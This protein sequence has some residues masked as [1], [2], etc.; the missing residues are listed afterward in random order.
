MSETQPNILLIVVDQWRSDTLGCA[1]HPCVRTPHLDRL[2]AD[3]VRFTNAYSATPTC[4]AARASLLTGLSQERHGIVGYTESVDWRYETTLAGTLADAGYHTQCV[5]KMHV[6][7]YRNLMGFH[8]VVLHDGYLHTV[9]AR[10]DDYTL[11]DDY[12][13]DLRRRLGRPEAD[14]LDSGI[15]CN[16]YAVAPWPYDESLHPTTWVTDQAV[17]FLHRRRDPSRPFFLKVSYHR[18]HPP[19][20]P[21]AS[22]LDEYRAIDPPEPVCGDWAQ[23]RE[24]P[25]GTSVESPVPHDPAQIRLARQAYYAQCTHIDTQINRLTH[26]LIRRGAEA[27][28]AIVFVS[29]HGEMLYDHH[30]ISKAMPFEASAGI[31]CI[32]RPPRRWDRAVERGSECD[33]VVELRD[34]LATCCDFA[35]IDR[36]DTDGL[37]MLGAAD[38]RETRP[39]LHGEHLQGERS[40][41]WLTDGREKYIWWSQTGEESFFDLTEDPQ[42]LHEIAA[43]NPERVTTWRERMVDVLRDREEGFVDDDQLVAGRPQTAALAHAGTDGGRTS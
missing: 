17:D 25:H 9:Q 5:G 31:P 20:D 41:Q 29:D 23:D 1:G 15:G 11:Y 10:T 6:K 40:N 7:P 43:D 28:T 21:P 8:N 16:G 4:V 19:L 30:Q 18:P 22:F 35:G 33:E 38:G 34:V 12:L 3:G 13:P 36:P 26:A 2:A 37:S 27:N 39:W 42:E 14:F 24:L 32:V